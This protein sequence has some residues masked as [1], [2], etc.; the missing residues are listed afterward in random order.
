MNA[1]RPLLADLIEQIESLNFEIGL[2]VLSGFSVVLRVLKQD[3]TLLRLIT[4]LRST[5]T[6][7][8]E[9]YTRIQHLLADNP[10]PEYLNTHDAALTGY[11]Y[12]L[13]E[14]NIS[15]T[16]QAI[17]AVIA[18]PNLWWA[19]RMAQYIKNKLPNVASKSQIVVAPR[20]SFNILN[21]RFDESVKP[22]DAK[23]IEVSYHAATYQIRANTQNIQGTAPFKK[24]SA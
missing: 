20:F 23:T 14:A 4:H 19:N 22:H 12:A 15:L 3:E 13:S 11:L 9:V 5:S 6:A 17:E 8:A 16:Q 24:E 21:S 1:T 18:T 10:T 7:G 2:T